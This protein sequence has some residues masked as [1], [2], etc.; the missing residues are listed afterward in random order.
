MII[1]YGKQAGVAKQT[2]EN[3]IRYSEKAYSA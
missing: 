3:D 1:T 2:S